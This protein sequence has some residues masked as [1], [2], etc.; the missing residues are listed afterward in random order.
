MS[1]FEMIL[2][3]VIFAGIV[4]F[5]CRYIVKTEDDIEKKKDDRRQQLEMENTEY[6]YGHNVSRNTEEI[7]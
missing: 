4:F 5:S 1:T 7:F 3:L 6:D 2:F